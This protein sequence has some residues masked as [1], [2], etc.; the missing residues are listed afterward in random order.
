M[1]LV[2]VDFYVAVLVET[3]MKEFCR[4]WEMLWEH[5]PK[6]LCSDSFFEFSQ[7]FMSVA[8]TW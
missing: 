4:E 2:A 8:I 1:R 5:E 3:W 6:G 7:A